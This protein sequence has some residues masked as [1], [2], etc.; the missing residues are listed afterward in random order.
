MKTQPDVSLSKC[1]LTPLLGPPLLCEVLPD[2][3]DQLVLATSH[4][5]KQDEERLPLHLSLLGL[6]RILGIEQVCIWRFND[7][8][9]LVKFLCAT[10]NHFYRWF[11]DSSISLKGRF[12]CF[13]IKR[14]I[15]YIRFRFLLF[16][17]VE[18][19]NFPHMFFGDNV[20]NIKLNMIQI[21]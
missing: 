6:G 16:R 14:N 20:F 10:L 21:S 13:L 7:Y 2:L 11:V 3:A 8:L 15:T 18:R 9:W 19:G 1:L 12:S 17:M 5:V 4:A